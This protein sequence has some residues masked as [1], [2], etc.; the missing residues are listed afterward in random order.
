MRAVARLGLVVGSVALVLGPAACGAG[1]VP[2]MPG[3]MMRPSGSATVTSGGDS[4]DR[5][6]APGGMMGRLTTT[7][8]VPH[9][10][11]IAGEGLDAAGVSSLQAAVDQ[12]AQP[13]RL[14]P[15]MTALAFVRERFGWMMPRV[16]GNGPT[17]ML[18]DDG[19]GGAASLTIAQP[20]RTG[21]D[22]I[23]MVTGGTWLR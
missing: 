2:T 23:W 16:E 7:T 19:V 14:L 3:P 15:E 13:W 21:T 12:G 10:G 9:S 17:R 5:D 6:G 1:T 22:G 8:A 4:A 11:P 20:G 18:V